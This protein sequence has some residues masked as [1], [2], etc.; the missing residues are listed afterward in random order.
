MLLQGELVI[1][2]GAFDVEGNV[3]PAGTLDSQSVTALPA[4]PFRLSDL[5]GLNKLGI[6]CHEKGGWIPTSDWRTYLKQADREFSKAT[7]MTS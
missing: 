5:E 1:L 7:W 4:L 6:P 2:G 3:N